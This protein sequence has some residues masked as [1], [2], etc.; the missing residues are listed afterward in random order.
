MDD[1]VY[2]RIIRTREDDNI[3]TVVCMQ[4]FDEDAYDV[5]RFLCAKGTDDRLI[6]STVE[7]AVKFLNDNI[8]QEFIDPEYRCMTQEN[9][10]SFYK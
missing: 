8:K 9:N 1:D 7:K 6:F 10:D 3:L 5:N 4:W 2:Y